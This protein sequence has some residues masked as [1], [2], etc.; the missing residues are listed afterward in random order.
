MACP[1]IEPEQ[2]LE[3]ATLLVHGRAVGLVEKKERYQAILTLE[4]IDSYKGAPE[5][6]EI[7]FNVTIQNGINCGLGYYVASEY[8]IWSY[9][10]FKNG[11]Y[12]TFSPCHTVGPG[13]WPRQSRMKVHEFLKTLNNGEEG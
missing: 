5:S 13:A 4:V 12:Y 3:K 2:I 9:G 8:V 10:D 6:G 7:E 1:V 11:E